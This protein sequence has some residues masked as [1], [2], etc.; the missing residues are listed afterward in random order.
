MTATTDLSWA[1]VVAKVEPGGRFAGA[2]SFAG[3]LSSD[4]TVVEIETAAGA[5]R[6][7][8][9]RRLRAGRPARRRSIAREF[10]L[11][12]CLHDHGI[13]VPPP[14]DLDDSGAAVAD[15]YAVYGYVP[16]SLRLATE[17]PVGTGRIYAGHLAAIHRLD[18][19]LL[20]PLDLPDFGSALL[21]RLDERRAVPD[22]TLRTDAIW[23][24]LDRHRPRLDGVVPRLVHGDLWPGNVVFAGPRP[25]AII[26]WEDAGL[27]DPLADVAITR[28]DLW[29]AFGRA[30]ATAFTDRYVELTGADLA[31]L[32]VWAL[33]AALRPA[34][35]VSSWAADWVS[36][37]RPDMTP[38]LLRAVH[39]AYVD[40]ALAAL[41][42]SA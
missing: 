17:D 3:G 15:T 36:Q 19:T 29:W 9:V 42:G 24:R 8:V 28:L 26:D 39:H 20:A 31:R 5:R 16:G 21:E 32:A 37:G 7:V 35:Y 2:W 6:R 22:P 25:A 33:V 27:G 23:A 30:A 18:P 41:G 4:M 12:T 40:D 1:S 38:A 11:I 14:V 10:R 13:P 34:G